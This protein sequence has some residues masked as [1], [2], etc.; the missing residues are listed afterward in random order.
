MKFRVIGLV[1]GAS[2]AC[3]GGGTVNPGT[4]PPGM[5]AHAAV[6]KACGRLTECGC[7][8][9]SLVTECTTL[10][11]PKVDDGT[12]LPGFVTCHLDL[13]C[14]AFCADTTDPRGVACYAFVD[15]PKFDAWMNEQKAALQAESADEEQ[16]HR[17]MMNILD[18]M[19]PGCKA[20]ETEY[21]DS[22]G[23][24]TCR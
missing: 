8:D 2:L 17:V 11:T 20:G 12:L 23:N 15:Q 9:A 22:Y 24:V 19:A 16:R 21:R 7:G 13:P 3:G 10:Y 1:L 14:D 18:N 5:D 6:S 4:Y